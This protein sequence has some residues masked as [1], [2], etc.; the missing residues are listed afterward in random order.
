MRFWPWALLVLTFVVIAGGIGLYA[1]WHA[2][3]AGELPVP[4]FRVH[5]LD[6][7]PMSLAV[8]Q[9]TLTALVIVIAVGAFFGYTQMRDAA[10][11]NAT[12]ASIAAA[13]PK[14]LK[15]RAEWR[16]KRPENGQRRKSRFGSQ[17]VTKAR[18]RHQTRRLRRKP[19]RRSREEQRR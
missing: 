10:I 8:L 9:I 12:K 2:L 11:R 4:F 13:V 6:T 5:Q 18:N 1:T 14:P 15:L 3:L 16:A 17:S 7:L 19:R